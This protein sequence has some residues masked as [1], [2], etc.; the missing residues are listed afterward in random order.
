[1][2]TRKRDIVYQNPLAELTDFS[3]DQQV[4]SVFEDMINRSVPSYASIV[5][6]LSYLAEKFGQDNSHCYDLGC[7]LG[8]STLAMR[9]GLEHKQKV[10]LFSVDT[11]ADMIKRAQEYLEKDPH[12]TPIT[13]LQEDIRNIQIHNA[14][15]V[16]LNFT[17]QFLPLENRDQ[18]IQKI[19][20]G[21]N[22]GACLVLSEKVRFDDTKIQELITDIHHQFKREQ[23]Y[24]DLEIAQKRDAIEN[25]MK[26]ETQNEHITRLEKIGFSHA[27]QWHQNTAFCSFLV[28]K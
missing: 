7:S 16:V 20:A 8:A 19:Y 4:V 21:M 28:I 3:F 2:P 13:F 6:R 9:K 17:L 1:M 23:G 10:Q 11:S 12:Q 24:S 18:L 14:S 27:I 15:M 22:P 26:L 25:I 5:H